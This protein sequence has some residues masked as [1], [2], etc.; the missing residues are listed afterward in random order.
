MVIIIR[1]NT[2]GEERKN[3]PSL[4]RFHG[5]RW[6]VEEWESFLAIL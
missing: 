3:L 1:K 2:G 4:V 5:A 6:S